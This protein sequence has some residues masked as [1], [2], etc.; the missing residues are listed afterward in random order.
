MISNLGPVNRTKDPLFPYEL[1][2]E[3]GEKGKEKR[4]LD[5]CRGL[6]TLEISSVSFARWKRQ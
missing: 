2:S 3:D 4:R 1:L 5:R 6:C